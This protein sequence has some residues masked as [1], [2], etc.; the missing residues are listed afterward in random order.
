M[1]TILYDAYILLMFC[2][3]HWQGFTAASVNKMH[4]F[5]NTLRVSASVAIHLISF[6]HA[7]VRN[8][9]CVWCQP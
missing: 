7:R 6:P 4:R 9:M 1:T 3:A 8:F 2:K 5:I